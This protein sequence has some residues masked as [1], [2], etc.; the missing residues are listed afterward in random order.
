MAKIRQNKRKVTDAF[1]VAMVSENLYTVACMAKRLLLSIART[2][3][4]EQ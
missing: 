1:F 3:N 2:L 4:F